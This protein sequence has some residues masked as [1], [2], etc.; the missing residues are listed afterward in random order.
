MEKNIKEIRKSVREFLMSDEELSEYDLVYKT[1]K[2]WEE[3]KRELR[4]SLVLLLKNIENDEYE[5][6]SKSISNVIQQLKGWKS[7]IDKH[8]S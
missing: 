1:K 5:E 8:L 6:G 4:T 7:K 2:D 3:A